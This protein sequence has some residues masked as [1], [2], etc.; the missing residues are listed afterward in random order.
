M[1]KFSLMVALS[2]VVLLLGFGCDRGYKVQE[3]EY[4]VRS[5]EGCLRYIKDNYKAHDV[6]EIVDRFFE[7][8][9]KR[10]PE[11]LDSAGLS[12]SDLLKMH[13]EYLTE[14][15]W[16]LYRQ[17]KDSCQVR[18][19]RREIEEIKH[20]EKQLKTTEFAKLGLTE[21]MLTSCMLE[22]E[23]WPT[24]KL[25]EEIKAN[26]LTSDYSD[27]IDG[28]RT[29]EAEASW[30]WEDVPI[31][32]D[33]LLVLEI[34][35]K[36]SHGRASIKNA[37]VYADLG[38]QNRLVETFSDLR[39]LLFRMSAS[40]AGTH[41]AWDQGF[42]EFN[43]FLSEPSKKTY[44]RRASEVLAFEALFVVRTRTPKNWRF[45]QQGN[46]VFKFK[47]YQEESEYPLE[48]FLISEKELAIWTR[49]WS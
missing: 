23:I 29:L 25:L 1:N 22:G 35:S 48:H 11:F 9:G 43:D 4:N 6:T 21:E 13:D 34:N 2:A 40:Y 46:P 36:L 49:K 39:D 14:N 32:L 26:A 27:A 5:V 44:I 7:L 47:K 28:I 45:Y 38:D 37:T 41:P 31:T 18:S 3:V 24:R 42:K 19:V 12:I 17:S 20:L 8:A 33:S 30:G 15:L 10:Y 16:T